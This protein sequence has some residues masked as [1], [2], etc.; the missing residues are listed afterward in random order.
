MLAGTLLQIIDFLPDN[1]DAIRQCAAL[2]VEVFAEHHP[3]AWPDVDSALAEVHESF[4]EGRI[5]RI[6]VDE[7][8]LVLGWIGG[9][10]AEHYGGF[11]WELHPLVVRPDR[12]RH[13]IGTALVADLEDH[14]RRRG[15][16]TIWIGT[17]DENNQTSLGGVDL[18]P[19]VLDHLAAIRNLKDHPIRVLSEGW[20]HRR[21]RDTG[22]QRPGQAGHHDGEEGWGIDCRPVTSKSVTRVEL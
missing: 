19:N 21:G 6:A 10:G 4:S 15:G 8:G 17:D 16:Y 7:T 3:N 1:Q 13:G 14:V 18:Y 20:V 5:S 22:R 9:I 11:A 12:Q 2:L